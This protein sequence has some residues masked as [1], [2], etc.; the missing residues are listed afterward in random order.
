MVEPKDIREPMVLAPYVSALADTDA[1][2]WGDLYW[3]T[4]YYRGSS[5][6][7][8]AK[9][10]DW[11]RQGLDGG[12]SYYMRARPIEWERIDWQLKLIDRPGVVVDPHW[13][14]RGNAKRKSL[15]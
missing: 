14:G 1:R 10:R 13:R 11:V 5:A 3:G 8:L 2:L 9:A 15:C 7:D 4:W 6:D 12:F